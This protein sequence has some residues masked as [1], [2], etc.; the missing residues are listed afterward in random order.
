MNKDAL[1]LVEYIP[2]RDAYH[3]SRFA[4]PRNTVAY[5]DSWEDAVRDI[6]A[7]YG[8]VVKVILIRKWDSTTDFRSYNLI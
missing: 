1:W 8:D 7:N 2:H 5:E 4:D 3:I 6:T